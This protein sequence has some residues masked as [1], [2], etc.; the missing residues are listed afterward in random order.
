[1]IRFLRLFRDV[2]RTEAISKLLRIFKFWRVSLLV[3]AANG[4]PAL[5]FYEVEVNHIKLIG[6][7]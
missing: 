5:T 4:I 3:E 7:P 2:T 6:F 1:M